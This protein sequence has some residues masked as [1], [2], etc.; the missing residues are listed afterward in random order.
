[1]PAS[2]LSRDVVLELGLF[3]VPKGLTQIG[4][5]RARECFQEVDTGIEVEGHPVLRPAE[6]VEELGYPAGIL[7]VI[8]IASHC[9]RIPS[10]DGKQ[11]LN[12]IQGPLIP[13]SRQMKE[14]L[15]K[16]GERMGRVN[17]PYA[18]ALAIGGCKMHD[19]G[20]LPDASFLQS[21]RRC[22]NVDR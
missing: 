7:A 21:E 4:L 14:V 15:D 1:M 10:N 3:P 19:D 22:E 17:H 5:V 13:S 12:A 8:R 18:N 6:A 9:C 16:A 20:V 2:A 11:A